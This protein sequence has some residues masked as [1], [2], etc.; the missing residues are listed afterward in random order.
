MAW[1]ERQCVEFPIASSRRNIIRWRGNRTKIVR[2][3]LLFWWDSH[4]ALIWFAH[5]FMTQNQCILFQCIVRSSGGFWRRGGFVQIAKGGSWWQSSFGS[6]NPTSIILKWNM[7]MLWTSRNSSI[8]LI[9]GFGIE[10]GGGIYFYGNYRCSWLMP[11]YA[12]RSTT[13]IEISN[14]ISFIMNPFVQSVLHG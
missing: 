14:S 6:T 5:Q 1:S 7:L 9:F 10:S 3:K 12:T 4:L 11:V 8:G 13:R 2:S